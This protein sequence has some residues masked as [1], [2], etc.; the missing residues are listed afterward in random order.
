MISTIGHLNTRHL[1]LSINKKDNLSLLLVKGTGKSFFVKVIGTGILFGSQIA[2][3]RMLGVEG[4]GNYVYVL[5]WI[6]ILAI[7]GKFGFDTSCLRYLPQY[8]SQEKWGLLKGF[9]RYSDTLHISV[10]VFIA[11]IAAVFIW[12]ISDVPLSQLSKTALY[13]CLLLPMIVHMQIRCAYL[14]AFKH[15]VLSQ[16]PE[17]IIQPVVLITTIFLIFKLNGNI[18]NAPQ[19]IWSNLISTTITIIVLYLFCKSVIP[20]CLKVCESEYRI[21]EWNKLGLTFLLLSGFQLLLMQTDIIMLGSYVSTKEAGLYAA[22]AKLVKLVTFGLF[23]INTVAVPIISQCYALKQKTELQGIITLAAKGGLL[24]ALPVSLMMVVFGGKLLS[25][26][27]AAF[28]VGYIPLLILVGGRVIDSMTGLVG[29]LMMM[30]NH[31]KAA[32]KI[33]GSTV[34]L[35]I[36]LNMLLIPGYGMKGAAIATTL[37][38]IT[39]NFISVIYVRRKLGIN[40]T[41]I[42]FLNCKEEL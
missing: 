28:M 33:F 10:S 36:I 13:G 16:S 23:A 30:T 24:Y 22:A 25:L 31:H 12:I 41:L 2:L 18:V 27:G 7:I 8:N 6:N 42:S 5:A 19:A 29:Y 11:V 1:I 38:M 20:K 14:Q 37:S 3:T 15:M 34:V 39:W 21:S 26:Y 9:F 35:N 17:F 40:P 32:I 4:Y